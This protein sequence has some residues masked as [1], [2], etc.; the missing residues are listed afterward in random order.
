MAK[1]KR[2]ID[3]QTARAIRMR[4]RKRHRMVF[5]ILCFLIVC[6]AAVLAS[7]VFF[8][9]SNITVSGETRYE[10]NELIQTSGVVEG[11]NLFFLRGKGI[12]QSLANT[13]P[14]LDT[15]KLKRHLPDTLEIAVTEREPQITAQLPNNGLYYIDATAKVLEKVQKSQIAGTILVEGVEAEKLT[16]GETITKEKSEKIVAVLDMLDLFA[17]YDMLD[18]IVSVDI[19]KSFD[20]QVN[21]ADCYTL[22]LGTLD[23]LEHK[24]QFLRS[25]FKQKDLP[26]TGVIDLS[27]SSEAHYRPKKVERTQTEEEPTETEEPSEEAADSEE[28]EEES[29]GD[30]VSE[31][32]GEVEED[33]TGEESDSES[34]DEN[35]E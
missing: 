32:E 29:E 26:S 17:Q 19:S 9:V 7:T 1:Q 3:P 8:R 27:D 28:A 35:D 15:I 12:I 18:Q 24:I 5:R 10:A 34:Y 25:I 20:V 11:D 13:Y 2:A 21:Y 6:I 16:P 22:E 31:D 14:Y 23:D 33:G 30:T 4:R